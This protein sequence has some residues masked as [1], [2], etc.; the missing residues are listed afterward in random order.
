[1]TG[2]LIS[3]CSEFSGLNFVELRLHRHAV[4]ERL[5]HDTAVFDGSLQHLHFFRGHVGAWREA[6][7]TPYILE[8]D[9]NA[10]INE[11]RAADVDLRLRLD[12][13]TRD[14]NFKAIRN[15]AQR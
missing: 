15:K 12:F 8:A 6:N 7:L 2:S 9:G 10:S 11:Q 14:R 5:Q 13:E 1:V 4:A 3:L